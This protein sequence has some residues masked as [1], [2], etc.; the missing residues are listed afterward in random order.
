[1][2]D[3]NRWNDVEPDSS[4]L[5]HQLSHLR[6]RI[7]SLD[8]EI[9][10]RLNERAKLVQQIGE[11]KDHFES[12]I[13]IPSREKAIFARLEGINTGPLPDEAVYAI[14]REVIS[15]CRALE[16]E[17][18]IAYLGSEGSYHH[19]VAQRHFGRSARFIP[20]PTISAIFDEVEHRRAHFGVVAI[21]N[22]IEGMVGETLDRITHAQVQVVG[23]AFLPITHNLIS[24]SELH[25]IDKVY[26]HPQA[27]AQC[28]RW[29]ESNLPGVRVI[30]TASTVLGV[31]YCR[32]DPRAAAI[33]SDLAAE[34]Y[35]LPILV[36]G[37][38][39][40]A[41]NT[42]RFF[43]IGKSLS[44]PTADDKTS[45]VVFVRDRVGALYTMLEPFKRFGISI[46]NIVSRP[47]KQEAWQYMFF[48]EL[49]G[50]VQDPNVTQALQEI[51]KNSLYVKILGSYPRSPT[52]TVQAK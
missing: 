52:S 48:L 45:L 43:V 5:D 32:D 19:A 30:D 27:L 17:M 9:L 8:E 50:H 15:A 31:K 12:D 3:E 10:L 47:V 21:E 44:L 24:Q 6:D 33:S 22:S 42:T 29:L 16:S 1:M 11:I 34:L 38:E 35:D 14:F 7:D 18:T 13:Y 46:T 25:Q 23:E 39:D 51:E 36:R 28:R 49:K 40:Y 26:S 20:V 2:Q 41:G 37:L 4:S